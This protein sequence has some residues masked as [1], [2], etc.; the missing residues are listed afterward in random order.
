VPTLAP[1]FYASRCA[2]MIM[3]AGAA[4]PQLEKIAAP[5]RMDFDYEIVASQNRAYGSKLEN[6]NNSFIVWIFFFFS[7]Y[8]FYD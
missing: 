1:L 2:T 7:N 8:E 5:E 4:W 3:P 6:G